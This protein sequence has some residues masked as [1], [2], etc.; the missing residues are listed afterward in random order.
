M[1]HESVEDAARRRLKYELG[2]SGVKLNKVLP[3]FRYRAEKDGVV[4]NEICPVFIGRLDDESLP[5]PDEVNAVRWI[6]WEQFVA[7]VKD[8]AN[9]YSPW[10][11]EEAELLASDAKFK[12]FVSAS[13]G[14]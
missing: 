4:E 12:A 9:G 5:N 2:I 1:L 14:Y 13:L 8:P 6:D 3:N 7:E 10:A 11:R